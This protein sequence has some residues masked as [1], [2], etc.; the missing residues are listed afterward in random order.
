ME[1]KLD[2]SAW[3]VKNSLISIE[4][5]GLHAYL[6]LSETLMQEQEIQPLT[7]DNLVKH[8]RQN[9]VSFGLDMVSCQQLVMNPRGFAGVKSKVA[10]GKEP[11]NG[12]DAVVTIQID[13]QEH[14]QPRLLEDG[15]V[16]YFNL[17]IVQTV[18]KDQVLATKQPATEGI[19]GVGVGGAALMAK[20][21]RDI[22]L[23]QG[24]NTVVSEDG[25]RLLAS[26]DG[27]LSYNPREGKVNVFD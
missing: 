9:G 23:P 27:H 10:T 1:I 11:I 8:L 2:E 6:T 19:Q 25:L 26:T 15:R 24:K 18:L 13:N 14:N 3:W 17:G 12:Q 5:G 16:D 4:E 21:G 7:Y 20:N 22:R